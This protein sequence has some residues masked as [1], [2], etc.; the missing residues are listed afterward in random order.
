MYRVN[1]NGSSVATDEQREITIN[2]LLT[3]QDHK[4]YT[5][6]VDGHRGIISASFDGYFDALE[7]AQTINHETGLQCS[8][9]Q[10]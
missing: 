4:V 10:W 7:A 9:E 1:V 2:V 3:K 8:I 5:G 6:I